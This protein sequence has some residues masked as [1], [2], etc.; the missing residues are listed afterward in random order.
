M[1]DGEEATLRIDLRRTSPVF[2]AGSV[3]VADCSLSGHSGRGD[4]ARKISTLQLRLVRE[5]VARLDGR[6]VAVNTRTVARSREIEVVR[7][8]PS[9]EAEFVERAGE[10]MGVAGGDGGPAG[11]CGIVLYPFFFFFFFFFLSAQL[12]QFFFQTFFL[13]SSR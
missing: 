12:S 6:E 7:R 10:A 3:L 4:T 11:T 2:T 5:D 9:N 8:G 13:S 1:A